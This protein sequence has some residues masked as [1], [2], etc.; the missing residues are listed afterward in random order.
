MELTIFVVSFLNL[1]TMS[2]IQPTDAEIIDSTKAAYSNHFLFRVFK[3]V[4]EYEKL[5]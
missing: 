1:N 3:N 4:E 2:R 5:I